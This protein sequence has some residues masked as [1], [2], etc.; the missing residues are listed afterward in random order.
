MVLSAACETFKCVA[1][2]GTLLLDV[3][4][5][6]D[7]QMEFDYMKANGVQSEYKNHFRIAGVKL[8]SDGSPQG[9]RPG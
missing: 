6:P 2:S 3:Y 8:S 4:A 9:K 1:D 7:I 5:Y